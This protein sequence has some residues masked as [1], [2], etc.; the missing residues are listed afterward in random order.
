VRLPDGRPLYALVAQ[1]CRYLAVAPPDIFNAS[2]KP[3]MLAAELG[4]GSLV[5]VAVAHGL[6]H[7]VQIIEARYAD[8]FRWP[9]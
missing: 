2:G 9:S 7:A 5:R 3:I 8:P 1:Q 6:M 4:A